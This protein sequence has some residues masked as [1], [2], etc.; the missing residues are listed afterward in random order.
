MNGYPWHVRPL[1][2]VDDR[3]YVVQTWRAN[4]R[5]TRE[6]GAK[7]HAEFRRDV[8]DP[9][10]RIMARPDT[11]VLI[12]SPSTGDELTI[13]GYLVYTPLNVSDGTNVVHYLYTRRGARG[14]SCAQRLAT[15]AGLNS[16]PILYTFR[17]PRAAALTSVHPSALYVAPTDFLD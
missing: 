1:I 9:I 11:R 14:T 17:G 7:S 10:D 4:L 16:G 3:R 15:T 5:T 13:A 6:H 8:D 12:A 2:G